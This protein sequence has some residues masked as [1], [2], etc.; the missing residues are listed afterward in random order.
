MSEIRHKGRTIAFVATMGALHD[1]HLSL[2]REA[3]SMA[4][5]V[6]LSIFVNPLQFGPNEDFDRYP[7]DERQ[8]LALAENE[9]TDITFLPSVEE[10]YPEGASTTVSV[11]RLGEVVEGAER[12][13]HFDGVATVVVKLLNIVQPTWALF[14]Q[15]DAQQVA[16]I[17]RVVQDLALPVEIVV[18]PTWRRSH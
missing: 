1:G 17:K 18:C 6:V 15:K 5:V 10:M 8:D 16:V 7:R 11:G 4:D 2:L 9:G 3:R 14:G 13:G 12:P